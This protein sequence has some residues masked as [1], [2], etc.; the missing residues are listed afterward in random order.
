MLM[1]LHGVD[2]TSAP[3][4]RK[5]ITIASGTLTG[6]VLTISALESLHDFDGF[7]QWLRRPGPWLAGFDLPFSLP[8]E[9]VEHLDWPT[10]W[11]ALVRQ[12]ATL[13]RAQLRLT[14]KAFCDA[15]PV[16]GK[17]AHRAT[18]IPAGSSSSMKWVNP[19]VAYMLHAGVPRLLDAGVTIPG[20]HD[21]DVLHRRLALEAYPGMV[22]RSITKASYKSDERAKQTPARRQAREQIVAALEQGTYRFGIVVDAGRHRAALI[23]DGSGDWLD[24]VL[25]AVLAA[26]A[27]QR[28][29][30]GFGLPPFDALEGWIVGAE[31]LP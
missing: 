28:R 23:E 22:A 27:W 10:A 16:G 14:F 9:L 19:P 17:F 15:R 31:V 20:M 11:P 1:A 24:A 30:A 2:F 21:G 6:A 26:W 8:R 12:V 4:R 5:G 18:D 29:D 3:T 7:E 25:C 13:S